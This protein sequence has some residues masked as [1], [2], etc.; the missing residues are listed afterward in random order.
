MIKAIKSHVPDIHE[1]CFVIDECSVSGNVTMKEKANVWYY[2]VI[3]GDVNSI[4]IGKY[5][6]VQDGAIIHVTKDTKTVIGDYVS[7][8]HGAKLHGCTV[9]DRALIGIGAIVLDGAEIGEGSVVAA[10][11]V[12]P[13]GKV[14]PP[15][16]VVAGN[17]FRVLREV[18][19]AERETQMAR[20]MKYAEVYPLEYLDS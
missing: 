5:S 2:A 15:N 6:N 8:G 1:S 11:T 17:P 14:V 4:E 9:H 16:V 7:I 18:K 20:C 19:D 10:G 13:P 12:I 3:R